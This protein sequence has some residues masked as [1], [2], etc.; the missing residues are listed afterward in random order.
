MLLHGCWRGKSFSLTL[1]TV[2]ATR[3]GRP[4][5]LYTNRCVQP[6]KTAAK[7]TF[8]IFILFHHL[9]CQKVIINLKDFPNDKFNETGAT[10]PIR[11][12]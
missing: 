6:K 11:L 5:T 9:V 10:Q 7:K 1:A 2:D 4:H 8:K 3:V 12:T